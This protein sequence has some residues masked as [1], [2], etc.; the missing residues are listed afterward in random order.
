MPIDNLMNL[1]N[2]ILIYIIYG[3]FV[4]IERIPNKGRNYVYYVYDKKNDSKELIKLYNEIRER[5]YKKSIRSIFTY[6]DNSSKNERE[7]RNLALMSEVDL[8][9]KPICYTRRYFRMEFLEGVSGLDHFLSIYN[10]EKS[11][12]LIEGT[13]KNIRRM[14]SM[15]IYHAD[16]RPDNILVYERNGKFS[17]KIIDFEH[18]IDESRYSWDFIKAFDYYRFALHVKKME[19]SVD[20]MIFNY[21]SVNGE[22]KIL[23][24]FEG[25]RLNN[26]IV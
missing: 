8:S 15:N 22:K 6:A 11:I 14:H 18:R 13:L 3:R 20:E 16:L 17:F 26:I 9:P 19:P 10:G 2:Y 12:E 24:L 4:D 21:L 1:G 25:M 23:E 7:F 5:K